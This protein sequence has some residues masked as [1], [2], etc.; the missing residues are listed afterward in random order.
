MTESKKAKFKRLAELRGERILKD[1]QLL[2]N[3]SNRNNYEYTE[4][5][6]KL[7]FSTI[8][9]ELRLSKMGFQQKKKRGINL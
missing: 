1:L 7:I 8:E 4:G 6:V 3:L 9:E 5:D 2:S